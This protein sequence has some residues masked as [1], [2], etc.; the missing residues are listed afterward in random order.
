MKELYFKRIRQFF[1]STL[2]FV[3]L[4]FFACLPLYPYFKLPLHPNLV[5]GML[6]F[7]LV[8]GMVFIAIALF[9]RKRLFPISVKE[10]YWSQKATT[11]YFWI[12]FLVGI[13]FAFSFLAYI[14]FA[15]LSLLIE[16]YFLTV[17]GLILLRPKKEDIT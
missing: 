9:F 7:N 17:F 2:G 4:V 5:L 3:S 8:L 12:Y 13:P 10:P 14:V 1:F 6:A 11:R 15:V 16:G